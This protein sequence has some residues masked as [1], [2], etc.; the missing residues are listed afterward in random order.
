VLLAFGGEKGEAFDAVRAAHYAVSQGERDAESAAIA[1]PVFG[2]DQ[3]LVCAISLGL[4]R[5]R[6]DADAFAA[7]LPHVM[8]AGARLTADLGGDASVFEPPFGKLKG[9]QLPRASRRQG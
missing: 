5:F 2:I 4:P 3:Q 7:S 1:C 9:L 6:F 8:A